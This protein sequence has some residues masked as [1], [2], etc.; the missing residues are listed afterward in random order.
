MNNVEKTI[1][2]LSDETK[3][4]LIRDYEK[5][6]AEGAVGECTLLSLASEMNK[7]YPG[8]RTTS[9]WMRAIADD[10]YHYFAWKYI[11]SKFQK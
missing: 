1:L 5:L 9:A 8:V 11:D 3:V 7:R 10:C 2:D 4:E 6:E